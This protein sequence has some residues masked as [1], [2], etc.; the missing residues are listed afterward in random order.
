ME[1]PYG[2]KKYKG[3][4]SPSRLGPGQMGPMTHRQAA[5]EEWRQKRKRENQPNAFS[6]FINWLS[7]GNESSGSGPTMDDIFGR[8]GPKK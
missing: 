6:D 2:E 4:Y 5:Y 1:N 7:S 8:I 3:D